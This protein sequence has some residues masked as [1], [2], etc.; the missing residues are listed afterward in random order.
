LN[1]ELNLN[2]FKNRE[3]QIAFKN[4]SKLNFNIKIAY[5]IAEKAELLRVLQI[6]GP[7]EK[8]KDNELYVNIK[9]RKPERV[10]YQILSKVIRL[11]SHNSKNNITD[12]FTKRIVGLNNLINEIK[13][14][15]NC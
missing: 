7:W 9:D 6:P 12:N 3:P 13:S 5:G 14:N 8:W 10:K 1:D 11:N 2:S 15:N 4:S